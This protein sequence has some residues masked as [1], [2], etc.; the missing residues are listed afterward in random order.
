MG[1]EVKGAALNAP[2]L[3]H[4]DNGAGEVADVDRIADGLAVVQKGVAE[5]QLAESSDQVQEAILVSKDVCWANDYR[6][7]VVFFP[8][9][10]LG[11]PLGPHVLA[12][13]RCTG[14]QVG[15]VDQS[16]NALGT[17]NPCNAQGAVN[18]G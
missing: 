8:Q 12:F 11:S 17:A 13:A 2:C 6:A 3:A 5:W 18:I 16:G 10:L 9:L 15:D 1:T 4:A 14:L 7:V